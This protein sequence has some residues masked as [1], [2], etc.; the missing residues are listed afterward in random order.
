MSNIDV[1]SSLV[2]I[3]NIDGKRAKFGACAS[4]HIFASKRVRLFELKGFG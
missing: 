4:Y 1:I 3:N 2:I